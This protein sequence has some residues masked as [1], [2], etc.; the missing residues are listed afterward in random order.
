MIVNG[1]TVTSADL[2]DE[3]ISS[4]MGMTR[5]K[6]Q[7]FDY[8]Q[9]L[10]KLV[11]DRLLAQEAYALG[12]GDDPELVASLENQR[13]K[14]AAYLWVRDN[15][16]PHLEIPEA[17]ILEYFDRQYRQVVLRVIPVRSPELADTLGHL[18]RLGADMDSLARIHA[19]G[20][21]QALGGLNPVTRRIDL[22]PELRVLSDT[23]PI[24]RISEPFPFKSVFAIARVESNDEADRS[25]L[26]S[27][28]ASIVAWLEKK[29]GIAQWLAFVEQVHAQVKLQTDSLVLARIAADSALL[30]TQDYTIGSDDPV[31]SAG[32]LV[33]TE[34]ELRTH[35]ARAAMSAANRPY[36]EL[37][38]KG[39]QDM[40]DRLVMTAAAYAAGYQDH[41]E[42]I[43]TYNQ[44]LDSAVVQIY[45]QETVAPR[46][47]FRRDE[48][49][50]YYDEHVADFQKPDEVQFDRMIAGSEEVARDVYRHYRDGADFRFLSRKYGVPTAS[51][52][53]TGEWLTLSAL[54]QPIRREIDTL[55]IGDCVQPHQTEDGWLI[56][57]I[58]ARRPGGAI[59][60]NEA[61]Q[62]IRE[63]MFQR[64]FKEELDAVL[65]ILKDNSVI[66]YR[67]KDIDA[68][69]SGQP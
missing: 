56:L 29:T 43:A 19:V 54:P 44:A 45:L 47:V 40:G 1:D 60:M 58:K 37:L 4:H 20:R 61:E 17:E 25:E 28:R 39:L 34:K 18:I 14:Q 59:A 52:E 46:I 10:D 22:E 11:N 62:R 32:G 69:F 36:A 68:Y 67:E 5:A 12:L 64:K 35:I 51:P 42:V 21:M 9:L 63:L 41:P 57:R 27:R 38:Q 3:L 2:D 65:A 48:F 8:R 33:A 16:R 7:D 24:G 26:E 15:Y 50:T 55:Q 30:F 66:E 49:E 53:E 13:E 23:I 31:L 6:K